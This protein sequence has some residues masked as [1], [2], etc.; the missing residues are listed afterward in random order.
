MPGPRLCPHSPVHRAP[1]ATSSHSRNKEASMAPGDS[2]WVPPG[3]PAP[4]RPSRPFLWGSDFHSLVPRGTRCSQFHFTQSIS[5]SV[6]K[7][8]A[9]ADKTT[10]TS[11]PPLTPLV[12]TPTVHA[13]SGGFWWFQRD[14]RLH[15]IV[16]ILATNMN[17]RALAIGEGAARRPWAHSQ[18][19]HPASASRTS[20]SSHADTLSPSHTH[21]PAPAPVTYSVSAT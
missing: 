9:S 6:F 18:V 14:G 3:P 21:P 10:E 19:A 8:A 7:G 4:P 15:P 5:E 11:P 13:A 20:S 2:E 1:G 12:C 16:L 17:F